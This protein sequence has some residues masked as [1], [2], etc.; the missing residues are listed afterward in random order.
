MSIRVNLHSRCSVVHRWLGCTSLAVRENVRSA[1]MR[2]QEGSWKDCEFGSKI[3]ALEGVI[4]YQFP[5]SFFRNN[6]I[7]HWFGISSPELSRKFS[8]K[9]PVQNR[10]LSILIKQYQ[11]SN[12]FD[13]SLFMKPLEEFKE[14]LKAAR[15]GTYGAHASA[16][17]RHV[18][19]SRGK[20]NRSRI[21]IRAFEDERRS[22][23][24]GPIDGSPDDLAMFKIGQ[25]V[26]IEVEVPGAGQLIVLNEKV[27]EEIFCL[28]PSSYS[29]HL[30]AREGVVRL[31][32][33]DVSPYFRINAPAGPYRVTAIW[34]DFAEDLPYPSHDEFDETFRQLSDHMLIDVCDRIQALPSDRTLIMCCDYFVK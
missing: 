7:A 5:A 24:I 33:A 21:R 13:Y 25:Q 30:E 17:A 32:D 10:E 19:Y 3:A 23:G 11:L 15:L 27:G 18:L 28:K 34:A 26:F 16:D 4:G 20:T 29:A 31:P 12:A 22:G 1:D 2:G 14:A 6:Q 8:G 9:R